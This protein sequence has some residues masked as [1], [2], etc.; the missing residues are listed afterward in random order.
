MDKRKARR[1]ENR[2]A[3]KVGRMRKAISRLF[4]ARPAEGAVFAAKCAL[5]GKPVIRGF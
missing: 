4:A 5:V 3:K 2:A 1:L